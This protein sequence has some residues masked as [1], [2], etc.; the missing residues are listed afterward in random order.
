MTKVKVQP[1]EVTCLQCGETF[2]AWWSGCP[3]CS[4]DDD[5]S[6]PRAPGTYKRTPTVPTISYL[7]PGEYVKE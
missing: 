2:P 3:R 4:A 1:N 5:G 6:E 7:R